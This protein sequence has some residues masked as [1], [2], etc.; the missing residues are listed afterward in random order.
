MDVSGFLQYETKCDKDNG[1]FESVV[2]VN[3][4]LK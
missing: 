4:V 2:G 3:N 1:P